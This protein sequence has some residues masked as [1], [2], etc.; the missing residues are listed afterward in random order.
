MAARRLTVTQE[1]WP[2]AG[3]FTIAR[4][5]KTHAEIVLV[6]LEQDGVVGR[7]ECV[8]Y[9]RYGETI[10]GVIGE[11]E[12]QRAALERGI[13]RHTLMTLMPQG[14]ARNAIDAALIDLACKQHGIRAWDL[15]GIEPPKPAATCFTISLNTPELMAEAATRAASRPL[16]KIKLGAGS[17]DVDRI[18]AIRQAAP[19]ARLVV[20]ANEG[21]DFDL[22]QQLAPEMARLQVELIEQPLP[23]G[24]DEALAG[25][26]S[27]VPL[28]ADESAQG[29][30]SLDDLV[31]RYQAINIKLDKT[32]GLTH[33]LDLTRAAKSRGLDIMLG[34]MVG[35]SLGMAPASLLMDF[36]AFVD[37]D[38][39]LL[40]ARDRE[41]GLN[42]DHDLVDLPE[43]ALWG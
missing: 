26:K 6:T 27:P 18:A 42:Y 13:D 43:A 16:L 25:Y 17:G 21:W 29:S 37:L 1:S 41:P 2:I 33:A 34:C 12:N 4:G 24:Q 9:R 23:A 40:L 20:D 14:A 32:G 39:P 3:T 11:I 10:D 38:G 15:I 35:T 30:L 36:A 8:P 19:H 5:S 22:L 31:R 7:G 28:C